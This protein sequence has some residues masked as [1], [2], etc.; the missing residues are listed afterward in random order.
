MFEKI[1][2]ERASMR[3]EKEVPT[4]ANPA[5]AR[6]LDQIY[7]YTEPK[8]V[9]PIPKRPPIILAER[10]QGVGVGKSWNCARELVS[11]FADAMEG[12]QA[13]FDHAKILHGYINRQ[14]I[15]IFE[16]SR[17][18]VLVDWD[19]YGLPWPGGRIAPKLS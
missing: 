10:I 6:F 7:N 14:T 19:G 16:E 2:E 18:G 15:G 11:A 12:H 17:K 13:L 4:H 8:K 1:R 3:G 9:V 5:I